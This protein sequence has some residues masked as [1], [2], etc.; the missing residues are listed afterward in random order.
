LP[1]A[2]HTYDR[3]FCNDGV[4]Y[5]ALPNL[6]SNGLIFN[7]S[8]VKNTQLQFSWKNNVNLDNVSLHVMC[9]EKIL[10]AYIGG[11]AGIVNMY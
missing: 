11:M 9:P 6:L 3:T 1:C 7:F 10:F 8:S 5:F 2:R 4:H